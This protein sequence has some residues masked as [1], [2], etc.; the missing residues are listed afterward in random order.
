MAEVE[1]F[2]V[3]HVPALQQQAGVLGVAALLVDRYQPP[4]RRAAAEPD[5]GAV[6]LVEQQVVLGVAAILRAQPGQTLAVAEA[7]RVDQET[8]QLGTLDLGPGFQQVAFAAQLGEPGGGQVR[9]VADPQVDVALAALGQGAQAAHQEQAMYRPRGP[10]LGAALRAVAERAG[11]ALG[12]GEQL[13]VRLENAQAGRGG[14]RDVAGEQRVV[15]VEQQRQ[16]AQDQ[17]LA[18]G[19]HLPRALQA[20]LVDPQE[21]RAQLAEDL[22]VDAVVYV[23]ADLAAPAGRLPAG[24]RHAAGLNGRWPARWRGWSAGP[25]RARRHPSRGCSGSRRRPG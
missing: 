18:A 19:E 1:H 4:Q 14:R 20:A 9:R 15:D 22:A 11:Q 23:G 17:A 2:L 6:E 24:A 7:L 13:G 16:Q 25:G 8:V 3:A 21:T 12:L 5:R 10:G